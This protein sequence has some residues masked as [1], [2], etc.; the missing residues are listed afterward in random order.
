MDVFSI[1]F[2]ENKDRELRSSKIC[3]LYYSSPSPPSLSQVLMYTVCHVVCI[4]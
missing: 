1:I 4:S 3:P 2:S